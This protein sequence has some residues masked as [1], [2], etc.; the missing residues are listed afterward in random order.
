[1]SISFSAGE[2]FEM[3]CR[4]ERNGAK[5]YR[6]AADAAGDKLT[7]DKLL[8]LAAMEDDH[9][10]T[11]TAMA[12]ELSN[13]ERT[14]PV[15]DPDGDAVLYLQAYADTRVF[16]ANAD[17][18]EQLTGTETLEELLSIAIGLEKESISFYA[19]IREMVPEKLGR[20]RIDGIIKE[21]MSHVVTLSK[22]LASL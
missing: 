18:S 3:A 6:N 12:E 1:M 13:W 10:R 4:M 21:E 15:F 11:F 22:E 7:E 2:I 16:D 20:D 19:G 17:P 5:F 9:L 14:E 8:G